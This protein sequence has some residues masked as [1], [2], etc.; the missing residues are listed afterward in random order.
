MK[1]IINI[2]LILLL[3]LT[4]VFAVAACDNLQGDAITYEISVDASGV[5]VDMSNVKVRIYELDGTMVGESPLSD[6]KAEFRFEGDT[7]VATLSGLDEKV[8]FSSVLLTKDKTKVTITLE[9][10]D[11]DEYDEVYRYAF[12][13]IMLNGERK[14]DELSALI[15]DYFAC[16]DVTF[17]KGNV[18]DLSLSGGECSVEVFDAD[19]VEIY[20]QTF[21]LDLDV[22]FHVIEL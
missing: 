19:K 8:S 1:K 16:R 3:A 13:V 21:D 22:R 5:S 18:V 9:N 7:F 14:L 12:T 11:Y 6:G 10:S 4:T 15:C 20:N 17:D 2:C